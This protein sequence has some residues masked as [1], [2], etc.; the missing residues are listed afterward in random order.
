MCAAWGLVSGL[1][2]AVQNFVG[3]AVCRVFLGFTEA[4]FFPGAVFLLS[5]FYE[6]Q[7]MALRTAILYSGSQIGVSV[8]HFPTAII[9]NGRTPSAVSSPWPSSSSRERMASAAGDG[10]SSLKEP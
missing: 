7:K 8:A 1:T 6:K 2:G 10:C 5:M 4:A 9:A 3:L